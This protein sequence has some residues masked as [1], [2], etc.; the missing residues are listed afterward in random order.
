MLGIIQ[1]DLMRASE[2]YWLKILKMRD[3]EGKGVKCKLNVN[4]NYMRLIETDEMSN[5][6]IHSI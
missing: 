6:N 5:S 4:Y 3:G 1:D 2:E